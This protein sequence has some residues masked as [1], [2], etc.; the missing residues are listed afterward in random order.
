MD[1]CIVDLSNLKNISVGDEVL[2][3]GK[4]RSIFELC[5]NLNIIPYEITAGLSKRIRRVLI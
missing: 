5:S 4:S 2:L 1:S 3:F